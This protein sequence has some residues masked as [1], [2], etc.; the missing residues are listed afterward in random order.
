MVLENKSY[1][2]WNALD[3]LGLKDLDSLE[4]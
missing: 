4:Y 2:V 3:D 1:T